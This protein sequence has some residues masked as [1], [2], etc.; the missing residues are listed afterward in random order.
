MYYLT[1]AA[2][3]SQ[4]CLRNDFNGPME[5]E[6]LHLPDDLCQDLRHWNSRYRAVISL[7]MSERAT[8]EVSALIER[9]DHEGKLLAERVRE[10]IG[11][12]KVQYYSEGHLR[13]LS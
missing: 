1:V 13:Y 12:A 7:G 3:Y 8:S 9:L 4:S 5:P 10:N 6:S 2:E 11:D